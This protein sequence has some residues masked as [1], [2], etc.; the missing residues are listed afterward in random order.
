MKIR[1]QCSNC[2]QRF[3]VSAMV[4][5]PHGMYFG[6]SRVVGDAY[7]CEEC[8]KTWPQR[9]GKR[10]DDQYKDPWGMFVKWWNKTVKDQADAEGKELKTY[11]LNSVGDY[12]AGE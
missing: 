2:G 3:V 7:Y 11:H 8:V 1:Y 12:V 9:N 10:F 6:G 5:V 4:G